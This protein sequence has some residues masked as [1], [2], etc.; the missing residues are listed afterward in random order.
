MDS[1]VSQQP[2]VPTITGSVPNIRCL[3]VWT[4]GLGVRGSKRDLQDTAGLCSGVWLSMQLT[5][6]LQVHAMNWAR[7]SKGNAIH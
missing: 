4:R 2:Q 7:G 1:A 5:P 3:S 6:P